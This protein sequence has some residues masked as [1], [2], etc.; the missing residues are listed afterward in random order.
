MLP[1][2]SPLDTLTREDFLR[3]QSIEPILHSREKQANM[4]ECITPENIEVVASKV[5][6]HLL[7]CRCGCSN[8]LLPKC[9]SVSLF[10]SVFLQYLCVSV[11]LFLSV[12]LQCLCVCVFPLLH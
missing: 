5:C 4:Y 7:V 8:V 9:V 6:G 11:S 2:L 10:L 12:F 1:V 3:K